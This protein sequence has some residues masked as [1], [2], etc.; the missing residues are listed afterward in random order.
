MIHEVRGTSIKTCLSTSC[1][2][3][4][5][6]VVVKDVVD[7]KVVITPNHCPLGTVVYRNVAAGGDVGR[8]RSRPAVIQLNAF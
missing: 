6:V 4:D 1:S 8:R 5:F 3:G 7:K 2:S